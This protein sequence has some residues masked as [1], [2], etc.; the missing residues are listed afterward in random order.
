MQKIAD[1][2]EWAPPLPAE[3]LARE[4]LRRLLWIQ[5]INKMKMLS[6]ERKVCRGGEDLGG[7]LSE[8]AHRAI[9][10]HIIHGECSFFK[11]IGAEYLA[12]SAIAGV[13]AHAFSEK[14]AEVVWK[15]T[16]TWF[17]ETVDGT[18]LQIPPEPY[19]R[20]SYTID[21]TMLQRQLL[22]TAINRIEPSRIA[23]EN[24][25]IARQIELVSANDKCTV[26]GAES[27]EG[28][29]QKIKSKRGRKPIDGGERGRAI[30]AIVLA[31]ENW[32]DNL[33]EVVRRLDKAAILAPKDQ[34]E[35][36]QYPTW[37]AYCETNDLNR[38]RNTL[39]DQLKRHSKANTLSSSN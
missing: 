37:V 20:E 39:L 17:R 12:S 21:P 15:D 13:D 33:P 25:I 28:P 36:Y 29:Q 26:G 22:D 10:V 5:E 7:K 4:E 2:L 32:R 24:Q 34:K 9:A 27:S 35:G 11:R 30:V 3:T 16:W 23:L 19:E 8:K 18:W 1:L 31:V 6:I 14:L 38:L